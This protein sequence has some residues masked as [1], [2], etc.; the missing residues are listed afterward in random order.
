MKRILISVL[1]ATLCVSNVFADSLRE[2]TRIEINIPSHTL[3]LYIGGEKIREYPVCVGTKDTVT[4]QGQYSVVYKTT[5]PYWLNKD[6]VVPPGPQN[7]LGIRWIGMSK[8]LGIHGNNNPE[9]I[10]TSAS[11][12][13]IRMYNRDIKELYELVPVNTPVIIGYDRV[14]I[15]H[16]EYGRTNAVIIYPDCYNEGRKKEK[17]LYSEIEDGNLEETAKIKAKQLLWAKQNKP[18]AVSSGIG[19]FLNNSLITCDAFN[20]N[21]TIF[22]NCFAAKDALG[23][24]AELA[25]EY[26]IE[27]REL[28][29]HVYI[30]LSQAVGCLEGKM[31]FD[32]KTGNVYI[33]MKVI[34]VN[35][36]FLDK[37][38]GNYDKESLIDINTV[39]KLGYD[40]EQDS[41]D[42]SVFDRQIMKVVRGSKSY[43]SAESLISAL[44]GSIT[45]EPLLRS[46][47]IIL[48]PTIKAGDRHFRTF[49]NED[50]IVLDR[51]TA[52][53][54]KNIL[55]DA[56]DVFKSSED[57]KNEYIELGTFLENYRYRNNKYCTVVELENK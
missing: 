51:K 47:D 7:P 19:V 9:S 43:I 56:T 44:K 55:G 16:D 41:V 24:T 12:G 45:T 20:D 3:G 52:E 35:G 23:I 15:F 38:G 10:G 2:N 13:C 37:A 4:P 11:A 18:I 50:D 46:V 54:I 32:A 49:C 31:S 5:D 21:G 53:A 28:D 14:R 6:V 29:G 25:E 39:E 26:N 27:I 1:L 8:S 40:Y 30:N 33:D 57:A 17:D 48:P 42:I 34:K 22:V 36:V